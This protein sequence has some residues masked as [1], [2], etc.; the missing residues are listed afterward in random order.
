MVGQSCWCLGGARGFDF[1]GASNALVDGFM[2]DVGTALQQGRQPQNTDGV[3]QVL[4]R[5]YRCFAWPID[6]KMPKMGV[7]HVNSDA[8]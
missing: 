4:T 5:F 7:I 2:R 3:D 6:G 1:V 8:V